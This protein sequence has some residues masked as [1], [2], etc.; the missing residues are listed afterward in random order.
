LEAALGGICVAV[1][2]VDSM[3]QE[4]SES[5]FGSEKAPFRTI[6]EAV[7]HLR[8]GDTLYVKAGEYFESLQLTKGGS[9]EAGYVTI[10]SFGDDTVT[11]TGAVRVG[12]EGW[13]MLS[14]GTYACQIPERLDP[15][16]HDKSRPR[17]FCNGMEIPL[18]QQVVESEVN[19]HNEQGLMGL[20]LPDAP[21]DPRYSHTPVK[22]FEIDRATNTITIYCPG[23]DP[24]ELKIEVSVLRSAFLVLGEYFRIQGFRIFGYAG[25]GIHVEAPHALVEYN[26][27]E[28]CGTGILLA[29]DVSYESI[30][31]RNTIMRSS[32]T[33]L[34]WKSRGCTIED[35]SVVQSCTNSII[36]TWSGGLK[37]N[38]G[39][40]SLIRNNVVV[41]TGKHRVPGSCHAWGALWGDILAKCNMFTGNTVHGNEWVGIYVEWGQ[42]GQQIQ[43]NTSSRNFY[44][45]CFRGS[46]YAVVMRNV[47][48]E[49]VNSLGFFSPRTEDNFVK[50]NVFIGG[51]NAMAR[52][53]QHDWEVKQQ[54]TNVI[55][56][57]VW[58][59][60]HNWDDFTLYES[61]YGRE[62]RRTVKDDPRPGDVGLNVV[63]LRNAFSLENEVMMMV[64]NKDIS[65]S[66]PANEVVP[67]F[68]RPGVRSGECV[69]D[70]L[71]RPRVGTEAMFGRAW[72]P[73]FIT[74][75]SISNTFGLG[76]AGLVEFGD[77]ALGV[78][79]NADAAE[80]DSLCV[81]W[82]SP[83]LPIRAGNRLRVSLTMSLLGDAATSKDSPGASKGRI[84]IVE[85]QWAS[86]TGQRMSSTSLL[87]P[88][89]DYADRGSYRVDGVA[90]APVDLGSNLRFVV[91][92]G[93]GGYTGPISFTDIKIEDLGR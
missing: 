35:N 23:Y 1:F 74:K 73:G 5:N 31:R 48:A 32:Q 43:L 4:T 25:A 15:Y 77:G 53:Y 6:G 41:G 14:E 39:G 59:S 10:R 42:D 69:H 19:Q 90:Q 49:N 2:Y 16:A 66:E 79:G 92:L 63:I 91:F 52:E 60:T 57:N 37:S 64:G 47:F 33:G 89:E 11:L 8:P 78:L 46:N 36:D 28:A 80:S 83:S 85:V 21:D 76:K 13:T 27:V 93:C 40:W 51:K 61:G 82:S 62:I 68:W 22:H 29:D 9:R 67:Y 17:A 34:H 71:A 7:D 38:A 12:T 84:P 50:G 86:V 3:A 58:D 26:Y 81:G 30:V 75:R 44:G 24:A 20:D 54:Q 45:L 87:G 70:P 88:E 55:D 65:L 72:V 56:D 18:R